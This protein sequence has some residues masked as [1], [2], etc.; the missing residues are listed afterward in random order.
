MGTT[1][2]CQAMAL[3]V[4][5]VQLSVDDTVCCCSAKVPHPALG[6]FSCHAEALANLDFRTYEQQA[7]ISWGHRSLELAS[8]FG[9]SSVEELRQSQVVSDLCPAQTA[10]V[11]DGCQ[12]GSVPRGNPGRHSS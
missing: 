3:P 12:S 2:Q 7:I 4:W 10:S 5:C 8:L 6:C 11:V 1:K 9:I